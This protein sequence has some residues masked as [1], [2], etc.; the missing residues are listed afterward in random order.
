MPEALAWQRHSSHIPADLELRNRLRVLAR[1][2]PRHIFAL[3]LASAPARIVRD[4][5]SADRSR[6]RRGRMRA[7]GL[8]TARRP[9]TTL[10]GAWRTASGD[11]LSK[12]PPRR[13]PP[14]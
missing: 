7:R 11:H 13:E 6:H 8:F 3:E 10:D 9:T 4:L 14:G 1:H 12:L 5:A 2:A